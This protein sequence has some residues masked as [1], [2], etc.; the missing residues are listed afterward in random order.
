MGERLEDAQGS[1]NP[2]HVVE[3]CVESGLLFDCNARPWYTKEVKN[4]QSW[5]D[6]RYRTIWSGG[7]FPPL[8]KM[9]QEHLNMQDTRNILGIKSIQWKIEKR[10]LERIGHVLRLPIKRLVKTANLGWMADLQD[11]PKSPGKK[12]NQKE[13]RKK[14]P[15]SQQRP[16][17]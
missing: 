10:M 4:L 17:T 11:L 13:P 16:Q 12:Q 3:A 2:A 5:I 9:E 8:I 7:R 15:K 14:L 1:N 6:Y